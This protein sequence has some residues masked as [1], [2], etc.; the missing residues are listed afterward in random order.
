LIAH[1]LN[2]ILIHGFLPRLR[3]LV[4]DLSRQGH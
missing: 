3:R 2:S 4:T 1:K